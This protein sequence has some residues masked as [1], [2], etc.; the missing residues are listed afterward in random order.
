MIL[1]ECGNQNHNGDATD[2]RADRAESS[3]AQRSSETRLDDYPRRS[4]GPI[5]VVELEPER[6]VQ[7][8]AHGRPQPQ[9]E[10]DRRTFRTTGLSLR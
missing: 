6:G 2:Y 1:G 3:F 8:E 10:E 5:R 7:G 9:T 4:G